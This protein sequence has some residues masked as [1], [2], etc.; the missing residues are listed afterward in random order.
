M[1]YSVWAPYVGAESLLLAGGML[2]A[3]VAL[4]LIGLRL[5]QPRAARPAGR[6]V[7]VFLATSWLASVVI[8]RLTTTAYGLAIHQ[9]TGSV[10]VPANPITRYTVGFALLAFGCVLALTRK[11]GWKLAVVSAIAAAGAGPVMFELPFDLVIAFR[12]Q[13]PEPAAL[14]RLLYFVPL[15][16][17]NIATLSLLTLSPAARLTRQALF[18]LVGMFAVWTVWALVG[19]SYPE[20]TASIALN[21]VSKLLSAVAGVL[22]FLSP[23]RTPA[24]SPVTLPPA[25]EDRSPAAA[26]PTS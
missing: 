11:H 18:A 12:L 16:L 24:D 5:R 4:L 1:G 21:V 26:L 8:L 6:L 14:Y 22:L 15:F 7:G 13:A 3:A 20:T 19:F 9:Q 17:F 23:P 25:G 10:T 2:A